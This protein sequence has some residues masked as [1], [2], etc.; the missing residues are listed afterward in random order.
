MINKIKFLA[1]GLVFMASAAQAQNL[2]MTSEAP[3]AG[4]EVRTSRPATKPAVVK[5]LQLTALMTEIEK[6]HI[7]EAKDMI[8]NGADFEAEASNGQT[9]LH[10]AAR[11]GYIEVV[12][13]LLKEGANANATDAQ[14]LTALDLVNQTEYKFPREKRVITR[15]LNQE[16]KN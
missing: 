1:A 16:M 11:K 6:G 14:G 3:V 15:L 7:I 13:K 12:K 4:T 5:P 9:A 2:A 10:T 8:D